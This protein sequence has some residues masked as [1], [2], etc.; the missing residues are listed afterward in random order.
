[1]R[2]LIPLAQFFPGGQTTHVLTLAK[3]VRR[4]GHRVTLLHT[5]PRGR[6]QVKASDYRDA[7]REAGVEVLTA[8]GNGGVRC[9][10]PFRWDVIHAHSTRDWGL[11]V[12]LASTYGC[13]CVL[14]VHG[15][16]C[17]RPR[18]ALSLKEATQVIAVGNRVAA[19]VASQRPGTVVIEN[20]VDVEVFAPEER[21]AIPTVVYLS[22]LDRART[23]GLRT[24][25]EV[26]G[27]L[28]REALMRLY[29]VTNRPGPGTCQAAS[30]HVTFT[31][32]MV[33]PEQYLNHA[34][35]LVGAGRAVREGMAAGC[36]C[37]VLGP[38]Y[39]GVL[40]PTQLPESGP[41]DFSGRDLRLPEVDSMTLARDLRGL[42][43]LSAAAQTA[44][45][46]AMRTHACR[47]FGAELMAMR[48]IRV[49]EEAL[50]TRPAPLGWLAPGSNRDRAGWRSACGKVY[51]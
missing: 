17:D 51:R 21:S 46:Q 18:Y 34:H 7:L 35:V 12:T 6:S 25:V 11:A 33:H 26:V 3:Y 19:S 44:V 28:G 10:S 40:D 29:V 8:D 14:T 50:V 20:G 49:Y 48:T 27:H 5:M 39:G 4:C 32:W 22:R 47:H 31:G 1:M 42:L 13:P 43:T 23:P 30:H 41:Q 15:L 24:L 45:I 37:I 2:V 9:V 36:A 16:G 38:R